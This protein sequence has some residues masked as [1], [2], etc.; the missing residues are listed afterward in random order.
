MSLH[1]TRKGGAFLFY[2]L[3]FL[4][5]GG[6][7]MTSLLPISHQCPTPR[8][9]L[10]CLKNTILLKTNIFYPL[11][12]PLLYVYWGYGFSTV[13]GQKS[14]E[15]V[16]KQFIWNTHSHRIS[17][18][19]ITHELQTVKSVKDVNLYQRAGSLCTA[20]YHFSWPDG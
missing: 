14:L 15:D 10:L 6:R 16:F 1:S 2:S 3:L 20:P 17:D 11:G 8:S 9:L 13:K 18:I 19:N 12:C 7:P 5:Q 4:K